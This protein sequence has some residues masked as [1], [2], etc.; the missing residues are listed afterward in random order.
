MTIE[1]RIKEYDGL[2]MG[3]SEHSSQRNKHVQRAWG[4][5][6]SLLGDGERSLNKARSAEGG[7]ETMG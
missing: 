6:E 3:R 1:L 2:A 5:Q 7:D 4:E